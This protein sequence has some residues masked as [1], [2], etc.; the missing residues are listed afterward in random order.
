MIELPIGLTHL[1]EVVS[2][3]GVLDRGTI[4]R[5]NRSVKFYRIKADEAAQI[6]DDREA[7]VVALIAA[8]KG[9]E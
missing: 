5:L 4:E 6:A 8:S 1:E 3:G 7:R 2:K 9:N